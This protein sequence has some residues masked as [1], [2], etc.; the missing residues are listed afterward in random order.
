MNKSTLRSILVYDHIWNNFTS[1]KL[2]VA[3]AETLIC[4]LK[5]IS[6]HFN[7]PFSFYVQ[8][9]YDLY[10]FVW[11][12]HPP[13]F[14]FLYSFHILDALCQNKQNLLKTGRTKWFNRKLMWQKK[15]AIYRCRRYLTSLEQKG[16]SPVSISSKE[17]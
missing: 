17:Q 8:W 12:F 3:I 11:F 4:E 5:G 7:K 2:H 15:V 1:I 14:S 13:H 9:I 6:C 10:L 16:I